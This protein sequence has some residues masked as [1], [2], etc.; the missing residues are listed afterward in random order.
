MLW[1]ICQAEFFPRNLRLRSNVTKL[2]YKQAI[3]VLSL[4]LGHVATLDDLD[5]D[6]IAAWLN[7]LVDHRGVCERTANGMAGRVRTLWTFLAKRGRIARFPTTQNLPVPELSPVAWS[8]EQLA[9]LF[10]AAGRMPGKVGPF[11]ASVWWQ[12]WLAWLWCTGERLGA[13]LSMQWEHLDLERGTASLPATIRKARKAATYHLWPD[14]V[15]R[16]KALQRPSGAV[17]PWEKTRCTYWLHYAKLLRIAGLPG[18]R[19]RK[20]HAIRVSHA[21]WIEANGGNATKR[22]MHSNPNTTRQSY[23]DRRFLPDD[24]P[25]LFRPWDDKP[26][27]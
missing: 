21:T 25:N 10:E 3:D 9:D 20:S 19:K 7:W 6:V 4:F 13:S 17:F 2:R 24:C 18:G 1:Q 23:L 16:L 8:P 5:D 26:M 12:A 14:I 22:L 15:E 11:K 27:R